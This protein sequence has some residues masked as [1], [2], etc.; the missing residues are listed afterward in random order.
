MK[1][2]FKWDEITGILFFTVSILMLAVSVYLCFGSDIWYDELFTMSFAGKN[3]GEMISLTARD[4]HPPLYYLIVHLFVQF[5]KDIEMQ[6]ILAKLS[7]VLPFFLCILLSATKVRKYFGMFTAGLF[8]F[9]VVSMPQISAYTVEIRMYGY[10]LLFIVAG[11]LYAHEIVTSEEKKTL[12]Y[13]VDLTVCALAACYTHYFACMAAIMIYVYLAACFWLKIQQKEKSSKVFKKWFLSGIACAVGYLPWLIGVVVAQVNKVQENYWIQ[14]VS[15]RTLGGCVKFVFKPAFTNEIINVVLAVF[16]FGVYALLIVMALI[17]WAKGEQKQI[18]L[19]F[20]CIDVLLGLVIFGMIAS[21]LIRPVFVYRYMLPALG[22][23]WL[24]FAILLDD[25]K[26]KKLLLAGLL[27]VIGITGIRNFRAFYGEE[28]WK[29]VQMEMAQEALLQIEDDDILLCNFNHTQAIVSYYL[30]NENYLWGSSPEEL[31]LEMYPENHALV[32]D[33]SDE[34]G[35]QKIKELLTSGKNVWF[36]GSGN[37]REDIR[38]EWEERGIFTEE[39]A[40]VMIERYW[41]NLYRVENR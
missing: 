29:K 27:V 14:P 20:G 41:F 6:V 34:A 36:L 22:V 17:K 28:M 7:S 16:L 12:R 33:F 15:L 26:K 40:S 18:P 11:M 30:D 37:V 35:M 19:A 2:K 13:W 4:V 1:R 5:A 31:I 38:Q 9:L 10:A 24:A 23:F 21:V 25:L 39:I 8:S 32:E 3:I